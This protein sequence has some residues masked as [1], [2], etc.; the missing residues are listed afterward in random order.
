M[1]FKLT[2]F[3][4][5]N[6]NANIAGPLLIAGGGTPNVWTYSFSNVAVDRA[7]RDDACAADLRRWESVLR[8]AL[9][10]RPLSGVV[11]DVADRLSTA[12]V[13]FLEL[14]VAVEEESNRFFAG[15]GMTPP[16]NDDDKPMGSSLQSGHITDPFP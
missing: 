1:C 12:E 10:F 3:V 2:Q 5:D 6:A 16:A 14:T 9:R 4:L 15:W 13:S 8:T 11:D 7:L